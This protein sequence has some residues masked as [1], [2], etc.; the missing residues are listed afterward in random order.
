MKLTFRRLWSRVA[1]ITL[2]GVILSPER[3]RAEINLGVMGDSLSDEYMF[4]GRTYATNWTEQFAN[5]DSANLGPLVTSPANPPPRGE[6]YNQNWALAG[7]TSSTVLSGGQASGLA[8]QIPN[9][10]GAGIDYAVFAI[11]AN[12]FGPGTTA[13][14]DIYGGVWSQSQITSYVNSVVSNISTALGDILPTG[15]KVVVATVPDYGITPTVQADYPDATKRQL[16]ANAVAQVNT[17]IKG[18]AQSDHIVVADLSAMISK[19][20]GSEGSFN[21]TVKI[22]NVT[23]NLTQSTS[24]TSSTAG[25]CVDGIHPYTT[26]Q[27]TLGN[28]FAQALDTGYNAGVPLFSEAQILQH[29]GLTY[30][31]S[32]TLAATLGPYSNYVISYAPPPP[33]LGDANG[34]GIVNGLD[35]NKLAGHW[36]AV[37]S[38]VAGDVNG[39]GVVNGLDV[40][41]IA[42]NWLATYGT[43]SGAGSGSAVPEPATWLLGCCGG[44]LLL[45]LRRVGTRPPGR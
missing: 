35:I 15:V 29:A 18:I 28:L 6:G 30:G 33:G 11:G 45:F 39:D 20:F 13:Y 19:V 40:N 23:I 1:A 24:S 31:G 10:G 14:N 32:D 3:A 44:T 38:N 9:A 22:G 12:D 42:G 26:L 21:T 37:G 8:A 17:G 36:L 5:Y 2:L 27:G 7:A 43:G 16:V 41:T 25:F 4:N 34:D